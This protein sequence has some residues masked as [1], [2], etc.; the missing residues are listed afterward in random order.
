M[1][2]LVGLAY[3]TFDST[4]AATDVIIDEV[5]M[6]FQTQPRIDPDI[7]KKSISKIKDDIQRLQL[8]GVGQVIIVALYMDDI[9]L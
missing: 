7:T 8:A 6:S 9:C 3:P 5:V 1:Q 2:R 4:A